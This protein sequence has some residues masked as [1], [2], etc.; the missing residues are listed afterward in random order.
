[1]SEDIA[2]NMNFKC[3]GE[4]KIKQS[5]FEGIET[6]ENVHNNYLIELSDIDD[7]Y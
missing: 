6:P 1:M 3:M 4:S 5:L 2:K 7:K